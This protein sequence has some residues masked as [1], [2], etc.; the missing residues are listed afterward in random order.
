MIDLLEHNHT[1][2]TRHESVV[3]LADKSL[4]FSGIVF[5][6]ELEAWDID[7]V[8][9][10]KFCSNHDEISVVEKMVEGEEGVETLLGNHISNR[11]DTTPIYRP[12]VF[13]PPWGA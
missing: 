7:H 6:R 2:K 11:E 5:C 3:D 12:R 8:H 9:I 1:Q 4:V 10:G 13:D